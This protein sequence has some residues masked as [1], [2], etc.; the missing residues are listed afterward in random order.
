MLE[1]KFAD[2]AF[3]VTVSDF[4][5]RW[6]KAAYPSATH[7]LH[8]IYNGLDLHRF[9]YTETGRKPNEILA[10]GRLVEKKG[11]DTL[12]EACALLASRGVE[13]QCRLIG[14]GDASAQLRALIDRYK[15]QDRVSLCGPLPQSAVIDALTKA[16]VFAAPC[17]V[18]DDGNRDGLPTVL[19]EA[20]ALGSVCVSTRVTGIPEL[21]RHEHTG[22]CISPSDPVELAASLETLLSNSE[23]RL[24]LARAARALVESNFDVSQN[25]AQVLRLI[26]NI[27][28]PAATETRTAD[29]REVAS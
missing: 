20:M 1:R 24:T 28:S 5:L 4:K 15:L 27:A 21:V 29:W 26:R 22:L 13:F 6:L 19:I 8:R 16:T 2:A 12:I 10:I 18:A 17:K 11:F 3:S 25:A 9:P 7:S 14:E 23:K